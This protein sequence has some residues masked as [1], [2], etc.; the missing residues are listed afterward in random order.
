MSTVP[1]PLIVVLFMHPSDQSNVTV[2]FT[3]ILHVYLALR[4]QAATLKMES[5]TEILTWDLTQLAKSTYWDLY[6]DPSTGGFRLTPAETNTS[7]ENESE[8]GVA[9]V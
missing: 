4:E 3:P 7:N 1:V 5:V 2:Q 8:V 9:P 6:Q